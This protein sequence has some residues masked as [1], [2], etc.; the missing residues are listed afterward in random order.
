MFAT[1]G[2]LNHLEMHCTLTIE[3]LLK[4]NMYFYSSY[5]ELC[6]ACVFG[7]VYIVLDI[8]DGMESKYPS[9]VFSKY[10]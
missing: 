2:G 5:L 10:I 1:I 7:L 4:S 3:T 8:R 9:I 6:N